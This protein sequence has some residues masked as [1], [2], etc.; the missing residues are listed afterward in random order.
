M[1]ITASLIHGLAQISEQI[2]LEAILLVVGSM[3]AGL[4][5]KGAAGQVYCYSLAEART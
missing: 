2:S 1:D 5:F 3:G 4:K